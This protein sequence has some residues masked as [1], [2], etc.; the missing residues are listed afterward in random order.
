MSLLL[1]LP[2]IIYVVFIIKV[3]DYTK[4][5]INKKHLL[6]IP[7]ILG[8]ILL[9]FL[10]LVIPF[11]QNK[12]QP[13]KNTE[14]IR[15]GG[16]PLAANEFG[17]G[18]YGVIDLKNLLFRPYKVVYEQKEK[19]YC[20]DDIENTTSGQIN[21]IS[22]YLKSKNVESYNEYSGV[23]EGKN[24]I[25]ILMESV[26]EGIINN[27]SF[28]NYL[29]MFNNGWYFK[30]YYSPLTNCATGNSEFSIM[31]SIYP[32]YDMCSPK[33]FEDNTYFQS[34]FN[35]FKKKGYETY[36][37]HD[38]VDLYYPRSNFKKSFAVDNFYN[39]EG[40]NIEIS[41]FFSGE[42]PSDE[43]LF[44][45]SVDI[46]TSSDKPFM[47]W[48]TTVTTHQPYNKS[49]YYGDL[50]MEKYKTQ[51][52]SEE[53]SRYY[54][55]M[56]VLDN[57]LGILLEGLKS[58]NKLDETVIILVGDHYPTRLSETGINEIVK[59]DIK[60]RGIQKVPLLIYNSKLNA[61][62]FDVYSSNVDILP[63]ISNLFD[64]GTDSRIYFGEDLFSDNNDDLVIFNDGSWKNKDMFYNSETNDV[65]YYS[66][67]R[68]TDEE[69]I[70]IN[71][72]VKNIIEAGRLAIEFDYFSM[73]EDTILNCK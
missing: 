47:S 30:N 71:K 16:T 56:K 41:E 48:I 35:I 1:L 61:Q 12:F 60:D 66:D 69:I 65:S 63:T 62:T 37:F 31:T 42:W 4:L 58:K 17:I 49:S 57:A 50:Y 20:I 11:M 72:K 23:F 13:V 25:F 14:L 64:L 27:D 45:K 55:K 15:V 10:T 5:S 34:I 38:Y 52:Y 3:K 46:M 43:E 54:S 70:N 44:Q 24:L 28:T 26:N 39:A 22:E 53:V 21:Q 2:V 36:Y 67:K 51:G 9:Y 68:Y 59:S 19:I 8:L 40:L 29:S 18:M 73:F 7:I 32:H 6:I 33:L